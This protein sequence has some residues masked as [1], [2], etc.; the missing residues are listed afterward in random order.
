[1]VIAMKVDWRGIIRIDKRLK[2]IK[3]LPVRLGETTYRFA[4]LARDSMKQQFKIQRKRASR[5]RTADRFKAKKVSKYNSVVTIPLSAAM[6]DSMSPHY[7]ALK[8]GRNITNWARKYY[9]S[10]SK[11]KR[12]PYL[13]KVRRNTM[14]GVKGV[15]FVHPDPFI[16]KALNRVR[17]RLPVML[18]KTVKEV[19]AA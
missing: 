19:V 16:N 11:F 8:S 9:S 1:M 13:S 17:N 18:R 2:K 14:G 3:G 6:L 12:A 10:N 4:K 15:L 5:K 7:V